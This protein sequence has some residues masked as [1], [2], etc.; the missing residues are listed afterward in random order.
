MKYIR[1]ICIF[2]FV[3]TVNVIK[4]L[5]FDM[6]Y[7]YYIGAVLIGSGFPMPDFFNT[8]D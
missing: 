2:M 8:I 1:H 7:M 6:I 3:T 4:E 5:S